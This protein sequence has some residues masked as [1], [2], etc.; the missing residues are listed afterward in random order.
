M[1]LFLT[2]DS[3]EKQQKMFEFLANYVY[4]RLDKAGLDIHTCKIIADYSSFIIV[5]AIAIA[6][7]FLFK[8]LLGRGA[9]IISKRTETKWDDYLVERKVFRRIAYIVP[10]IIIHAYTPFIIPDYPITMI[11]VRV[12][13]KLYSSTILLIVLV[14]LLNA[15]NDIYNSYEISKTHPLKGYL[16]VIKIVFYCIYGISVLTILFWRGQGFGWLA[17][18]GALSAVLLL[19]FKDPILGFAG[20]I[21]LSTNDMLRIGD[22]IEM[23]K[24][25]ADGSVIDITITTVKIQN[26]DK[27]ITTIPTYALVSDSYKNWRG[28]EESEGRRIKRSIMIDMNSIRLCD[29]ELLQHLEKFEALSSFIEMA[30]KP[31]PEKQEGKKGKRSSSAAAPP[32]TNLGAFKVYIEAFLKSLPLVNSNMTLMV[33][34]LQPTESGLPVELYLFSADKDWVKY[35][36]IQW[37]IIEHAIA[38][39]PEFDLKVFQNPSGTDLTNILKSKL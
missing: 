10:A 37:Q 17:G 33:R 29:D 26:W 2:T 15:I 3:P 14:S 35:E 34:Q 4:E 1:W 13:L 36:N 32:S 12:M 19:V 18:L 25:G 21:Q 5:I 6:G 28:M 38:I 23:P 9:Q 16:Q 31:V 24:Y 22:W 39:L 8:F 20:G 27:T 11:I 7:F 30:R